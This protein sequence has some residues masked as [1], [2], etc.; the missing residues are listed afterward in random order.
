MDA[1]DDGP[2]EL[3]QSFDEG[4]SWNVRW[5]RTGRMGT[6]Y[7]G[8]YKLYHI[9]MG[10]NDTDKSEVDIVM[11]NIRNKMEGQADLHSAMPSRGTPNILLKIPETAMNDSRE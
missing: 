4:T 2:G 8:A 11:R 10:A 1:G 9:R 5:S 7:T 6:Y 3:V